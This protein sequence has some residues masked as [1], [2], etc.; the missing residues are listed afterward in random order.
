MLFGGS[1]GKNVDLQ[2]IPLSS[3]AAGDIKLPAHSNVAPR[4]NELLNQV[5]VETKNAEEEDLRRVR[6]HHEFIRQ[7]TQQAVQLQQA[8][9]DEFL[10]Q[11]LAENQTQLNL[12]L[13][14]LRSGFSL[15]QLLSISHAA[16]DG[17]YPQA[18]EDPL[19][20]PRTAILVRKL[21]EKDTRIS[22]QR[23][24]MLFLDEQ[25]R[26]ETRVIRAHYDEALQRA[27]EIHHEYV[28]S[29]LGSHE[30]VR[31]HYEEAL[32]Y[33]RESTSS[34]SSLEAVRSTVEQS[35]RDIAVWRS[36]L[37]SR[38]ANIVREK[39]SQLYAKDQRINGK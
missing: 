17:T 37:E 26:E 2:S 9:A 38:H 19:S 20:H 30:S 32:E 27:A 34:K 15:A 14:K 11:Y 24:Q 33:L 13:Q 29:L 7:Q 28:L 31:K 1:T 18:D 6:N 35:A 10:R 23:K 8:Q 25:H 39:E 21:E 12:H 5:W 36:E 16:G 22:E 3:S 4:S